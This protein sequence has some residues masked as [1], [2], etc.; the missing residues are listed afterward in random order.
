[1]RSDSHSMVDNMMFFSSYMSMPCHCEPIPTPTKMHALGHPSIVESKRTGGKREHC[2][3]L[4]KQTDPSTT[5]SQ[6]RGKLS[7][8]SD[9]SNA[10]LHNT[11]TI[12]V[13]VTQ[14]LAT[15]TEYP[16]R[17]V[18]QRIFPWRRLRFEVRPTLGWRRTFTITWASCL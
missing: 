7:W 17:A 9:E 5:K 13:V 15:H 16:S 6:V 8:R 10:L 12:I 4:G 2:E 1:M 14:W 3:S 18:Y 11:N